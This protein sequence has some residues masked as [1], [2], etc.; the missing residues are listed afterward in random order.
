MSLGEV[1]AIYCVWYHINEVE[2]GYKIQTYE[3]ASNM[4]RKEEKQLPLVVNNDTE[5]RTAIQR[6]GPVWLNAIKEVTK[7]WQDDM[8]QSKGKN[9]Y[10]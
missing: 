10:L 3:G 4:C 8:S 5:L 9:I 6:Y 1:L 7:E 2:S